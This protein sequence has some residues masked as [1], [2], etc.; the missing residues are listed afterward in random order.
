M[1]DVVRMKK[2]PLKLGIM[3]TISPDE[4]VDMIAT[5]MRS[6]YARVYSPAIWNW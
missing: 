2:V 4:I 5:P 3:S 1:D 6:S